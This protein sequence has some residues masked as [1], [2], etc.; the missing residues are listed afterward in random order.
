MA[1]LVDAPDDSGSGRAEWLTIVARVAQ[2]V[3]YFAPYALT[4]L[5]GPTSG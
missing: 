3:R 2:R 4:F 5:Q 1:K